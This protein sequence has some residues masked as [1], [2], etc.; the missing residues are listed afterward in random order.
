MSYIEDVEM[1]D[2]ICR[3]YGFSDESLASRSLSNSLCDWYSEDQL[4]HLLGGSHYIYRAVQTWHRDDLIRG[5]GKATIRAKFSLSKISVPA[6]G[7]IESR[8]CERVAWL[9]FTSVRFR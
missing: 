9:R 5:K 3:V 6:V 1:E 7:G 4:E 2:G 8:D